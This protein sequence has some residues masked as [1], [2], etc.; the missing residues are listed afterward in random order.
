MVLKGGGG[1]GGAGGDGFLKGGR[2]GAGGDGFLKGGAGG[3]GGSWRGWCFLKG[4]SWRGWFLL[5]GRGSWRGRWWGPRGGG[6]GGG[7]APHSEQLTIHE[8]FELVVKE[9]LLHLA[10]WFAAPAHQDW[11]HIAHTAEGSTLTAMATHNITTAS[12]VMLNTHYIR[13]WS[14][15]RSTTH[16][17][18]TQC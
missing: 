1:R 9:I 11:V 4:G 6:G 3:D 10:Y 18:T 15:H 16:R 8:H 13:V 7:A 14:Q 17:S 12:T 2:G 5:K